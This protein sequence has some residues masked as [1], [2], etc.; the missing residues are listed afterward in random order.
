MQKAE[1]F[2]DARSDLPGPLAGLRVLE[3]TTSWAGPIW[4]TA[5]MTEGT[6]T[7]CKNSRSRSGK[8]KAA[9]AAEATWRSKT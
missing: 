6:V 8:R 5:P 7:V 4:I 9:R 1:F 2:R 3:I